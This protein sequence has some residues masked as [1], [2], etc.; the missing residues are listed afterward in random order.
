MSRMLKAVTFDF[1]DT[2]VYA[3]DYS[4]VRINFLTEFL[5]KEGFSQEKELIKAAYLSS[6]KAFYNTWKYEQRYI[7]ATERTEIVLRELKTALSEELKRTIVKEFEEIVLRVP[8]LIM[9]DAETVL[10]SLHERYKIG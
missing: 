9:N 3:T 4:N 10:Q 1:W 8:P 5:E 7:S 2:L 6:Q